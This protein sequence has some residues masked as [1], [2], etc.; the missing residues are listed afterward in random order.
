MSSKLDQIVV[1]D[2]EST[3]WDKKPPQGQVSEIVEIGVCIL[4]TASSKRTERE[5]ILVRPETST[6]GPFCESLTG[7]TQDQVEKGIPFKDACSTLRKK[8]RTKNRVWASYGNYDRRQFER[9]CQRTGIGYP[10]GPGHIN[11]K[12]IFAIAQ[13]L[14]REV[15][16][17]EA[18]KILGLPLEGKHHCGVDDAWNIAIILSRFIMAMKINNSISTT[19]TISRD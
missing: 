9:Q 12:T 15:G 18:L 19:N 3:C 7:L 4:E 5:S 8:F 11:V 13:G 2:V 6:V 10:F 1:I 14:S 16:M 17:S